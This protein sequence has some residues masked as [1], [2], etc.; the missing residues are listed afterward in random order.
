MSI[1]KPTADRY[2]MLGVENVR[3]WRIVDDDSFLEISTNLGQI[4]D[5]IS[6]VIITTFPEKP[7]VY[8]VM[9]V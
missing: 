7:V 3:S 4:L 6:L 8:H 5:V 1:R 9:D 2:G